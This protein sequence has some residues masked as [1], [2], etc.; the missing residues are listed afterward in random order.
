VLEGIFEQLVAGPN[1]EFIGSV[2]ATI[3]DRW[4][5]SIGTEALRLATLFQYLGY[6]G[7]CSFDAVIAGHNDSSAALH[8]LECNGRWG[9]VSVPMTL[10]N[11]LATDQCQNNFVI[12]QRDHMSFR[13][14]QFSTA[15]SLLE[16][17]LYRAKHSSEGV[18][19]ISPFGIEHGTAVHL[20]SLAE[21]V[22]RAKHLAEHA[23]AILTGKFADNWDLTTELLVGDVAKRPEMAFVH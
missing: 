15:V 17:L 14:C 10:A 3:G 8:W 22:D 2:P 9:G 20:L 23:T 18:V 12:V 6:F 21:N 5:V 11:R 1:G 13:P 7:R 4:A 16:P 19:L